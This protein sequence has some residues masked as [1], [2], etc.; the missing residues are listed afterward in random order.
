M[1]TLKELFKN[2]KIWWK[3]AIVLETYHLM[4]EISNSDWHM[5]DTSRELKCS[6]GYVCEELM[7]AKEL[8]SNEGLKELSRNKALR[9]IKK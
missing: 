6:L 9:S 5:R 2:E 8:K 7:L 1:P 4:H 3:K